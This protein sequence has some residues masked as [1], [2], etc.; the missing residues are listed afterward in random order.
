M[1]CLIATR[2]FFNR[3]ANTQCF[4]M[5]QIAFPSNA[6]H[7]SASILW[8]AESKESS[9]KPSMEAGLYLDLLQESVK[10]IRCLQ[11][12]EYRRQHSEVTCH[13][14]QSLPCAHCVPPESLMHCSKC[15]FLSKELRFL[16][17]QQIASQAMKF[18]LAL[19][20]FI[21]RQRRLASFFTDLHL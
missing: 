19:S 5:L 20:T 10:I 13:F 14:A 9:P 7:A 18:S 11:W 4:I 16:T 15:L 21:T 12:A 2:L 1:R 3:V 6:S 8:F 17:Q